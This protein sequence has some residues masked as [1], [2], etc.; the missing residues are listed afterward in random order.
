M[1]GE[2]MIKIWSWEEAPEE[3]K[4]SSHGGYEDWVVFVP[5]NQGEG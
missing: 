3:Y 2:D 5:D 4:I 1:K